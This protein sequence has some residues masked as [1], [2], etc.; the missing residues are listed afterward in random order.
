MSDV[1][2]YVLFSGAKLVA[3][4]NLQAVASAAW[5]AV[6][7]TT[8]GALVI[9][10]PG[11]RP[12]DLDLRGSPDDVAARYPSSDAAPAKTGRG[13]PKLG[14]TAREVTLLPRHWE[15]LQTQPGGA[16]ATLRR[17]VDQARKDSPGPDRRRESQETAHRIMTALAGDLEGYEEALRALYAGDAERFD[18][19]IRSWSPDVKELV[20]SRAA[21]A[22]SGA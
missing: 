14:V 3:R 13:R 10:D 7:G 22:L 9:L 11:G 18:R 17:L 21:A 6:H 2:H 16:S 19:S 4:G 8:A 1:D 12:V 20:R 5:K 15:W